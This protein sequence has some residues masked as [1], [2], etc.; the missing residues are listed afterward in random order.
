[1]K[2]HIDPNHLPSE[3]GESDSQTRTANA[4]FNENGDF[5]HRSELTTCTVLFVKATRSTCTGEGLFVSRGEIYSFDNQKNM[6]SIGSL[7]F[8]LHYNGNMLLKY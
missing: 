8:P 2:F 3:F 1:M 4:A 7:G 6:D 5:L